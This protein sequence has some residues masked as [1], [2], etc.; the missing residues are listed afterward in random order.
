M[1]HPLPPFDGVTLLT[2]SADYPHKN[3]GIIPRIAEYLRRKYPGFKFRFVVTLAPE[4]FG[5][6]AA[7][8]PE[9]LL[10]VGR[11]DIREC[12]SLYEQCD[13]MFLPTLLECFSAS[14]AEAMKMGCPILTSD[15]SFA[16]N[17]CGSAAEYFD[18]LSPE[19]AGEA[20]YRLTN[21]PLRRSELVEAGKVRGG[22]S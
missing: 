21:D 13:I 3:L 19:S 6:T 14:Y 12:P 5:C 9:W 10:P 4:V 1:A 18:P 15:L 17:L 8:I 20:V 11:V 7:T 22:S 16:R 2:V